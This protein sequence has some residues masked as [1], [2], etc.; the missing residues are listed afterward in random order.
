MR[1]ISR[2]QRDRND[3]DFYTLQELFFSQKCNFGE[4]L[5]VS[6]NQGCFV[7]VHNGRYCFPSM[8]PWN[9]RHSKLLL[10]PPYSIF[11]FYFFFPRKA[12]Y[13]IKKKKKKKVNYLLKKQKLSEAVTWIS[14]V[15]M[16]FTISQLLKIIFELMFDS[17]GEESSC[18]W[19]MSPDVF[20]NL[21]RQLGFNG[22][23]RSQH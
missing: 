21:E 2:G 16:C 8:K 18:Y 15:L 9:S 22:N 23:S 5:R 17:G 11:F 4:I 12:E 10:I 6:C 1:E 20:V 14:W 19:L 7:E 13:K 3:E